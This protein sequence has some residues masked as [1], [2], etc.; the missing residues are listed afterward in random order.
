[1]LDYFAKATRV[2]RTVMDQLHAATGNEGEY[3]PQIER[4]TPD[5]IE[6]ARVSVWRS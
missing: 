3:L 2:H 4:R 1:L 5:M 6:C